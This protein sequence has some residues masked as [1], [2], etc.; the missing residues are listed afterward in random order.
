MSSDTLIEFNSKDVSNAISDALDYVEDNM[1][2]ELEQGLK[3]YEK[4]IR[5]NG[6]KR[7][8]RSSVKYTEEEIKILV[9]K[10]RKC[11]SDKNIFIYNA[12]LYRPPKVEGTHPFYLAREL[13][14]NTVFKFR[15]LSHSTELAFILNDKSKIFLD[16]YTAY[17]LSCWINPD[18]MS[19]RFKEYKNTGKINLELSADY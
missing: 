1:N 11:P 12:E 15:Y 18:D 17:K 7:F 2:A 19:D 13:H 4:F 14:N 8:L 5:N 9:E 10:Q 16:E 6:K 3:E